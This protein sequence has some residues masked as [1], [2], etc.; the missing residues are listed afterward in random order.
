MSQIKKRSSEDLSMIR[1]GESENEEDESD[2]SQNEIQDLEEI[3]YEK[4]YK[5]Q[6]Q[7]ITQSDILDGFQPRTYSFYLGDDQKF[8]NNL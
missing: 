8:L 6:L 5:K 1:E 3:N 4:N 2:S 7:K